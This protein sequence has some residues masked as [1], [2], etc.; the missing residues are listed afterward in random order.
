M[1]RV[2]DLFSAALGCVLIAPIL[3]VIAFCIKLDSRG[4]VFYRGVRVGRYG[5]P[6]RIFKFRTMRPHAE[7]V[8]STSTRPNH[9]RLT[10]AG[11]SLRPWTLDDM[12]QLLDA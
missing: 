1:K 3:F 2:F 11:R 10:R 5:R 4:P 12:P 7:R 6:F 9:P 8:G